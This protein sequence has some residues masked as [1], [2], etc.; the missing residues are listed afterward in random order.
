MDTV[1]LSLSLSLLLS[2]LPELT[3][4][5]IQN[6]MDKWINFGNYTEESSLHPL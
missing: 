2:L 3:G 5:H 4:L 6:H 1:S